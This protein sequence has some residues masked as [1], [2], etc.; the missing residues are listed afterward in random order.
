MLYKHFLLTRFNVP[1]D[2]MMT[3]QLDK[4]DVSKDEGYLNARFAIFEKITVPS[5]AHQ[6]DQNFVW[7]VLLSEQTPETYRERMNRV[8]ELCPACRPVYVKSSVTSD[9]V[10]QNIIHEST[11]DLCVTTRMDN[12]DALALNYMAS[13]HD[14]I[15]MHPNDESY[16]LIYENGIQYDMHRGG[17]TTWYHFETNHFST[18]VEKA[19]KPVHTAIG[20][21]HMEIKEHMKVFLIDNTDPM[22]LEVIHDTNVTNRMHFKYDDI[23]FGADLNILYAADVPKISQN[24]V[25]W[26]IRSL[27]NGPYNALRLFHQYGPKKIALKIISRF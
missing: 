11:M 27:L 25:K 3:R 20:I 4:I 10:I 18:F 2:A 9:D 21:N 23:L 22:W 13:V 1:I 5:V 24:R 17:A 8:R 14:F 16:A 12:D 26:W 15:D 7:V 19:D 6:T